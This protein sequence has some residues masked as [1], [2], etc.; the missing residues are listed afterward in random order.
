MFEELFRLDPDTE[1][2]AGNIALTHWL[3]GFFGWSAAPGGSMEQSAVWARRALEHGDRNGLGHTVLGDLELQAGRHEQALAYARKAV[4]IRPSCPLSRG[5]LGYVQNYCGD[6]GG[7]LKSARYALDL[8]PVYPVWLINVLAAAYRDSGELGLSIRAACESLRRDP[9]QIDA[10]LILCS[11]YALSE[12]PEQAYE[13]AEEIVSLDPAFS[14]NEFRK[15]QLYKDAT[16][17]DRSVA[18]LRKAGLPE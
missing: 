12:Q 6:P 14:T 15:T 9:Q 18:A 17:L 3:D 1:H 8:D 16:Y 7:A 4:E 5:R 10:R 11:D 2:G 13:I